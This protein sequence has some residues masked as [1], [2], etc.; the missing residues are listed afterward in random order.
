MKQF[1][2]GGGDSGLI[3]VVFMVSSGTARGFS[4]SAA[5]FFVSVSLHQFHTFITSCR[6][7]YTIVVLEVTPLSLSPSPSLSTRVRL[8]CNWRYASVSGRLAIVTDVYMVFLSICFKVI[9]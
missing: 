7:L 4:P 5:I 6:R 8:F 2:G 9:A 3:H 1:W